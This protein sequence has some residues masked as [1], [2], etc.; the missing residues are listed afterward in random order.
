V[1]FA[2]NVDWSLYLV[3]DSRMADRRGLVEIVAAAVRGGA[4]VVQ[5]REKN[6]STRHMVETA[7]K[8]VQACREKGVPFLVNDRIDVALAV[9]AD[10]VHLGQDDMPVPLARRLLVPDRLLGV[11]VHDQGELRRAEEEGADHLSVA[12]AFATGTKPDHQTPLGVEGVRRLVGCARLPVVVIAGINA[13]NAADV[14]ETGV[15]GICVA[16]AI[17]AASDPEGAARELLGIVRR[18]KAGS[19]VGRGCSRRPARRS[20]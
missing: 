16:S 4:G 3:T 9:D 14:I 7:S 11:T 1:G 5:Y 20:P 19:G 10:G 18:A 15:D 8:L 2:E 17:M 6:A 12:P 13:S